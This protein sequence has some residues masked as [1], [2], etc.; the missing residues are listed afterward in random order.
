MS[1]RK[2]FT[3]GVAALGLGLFGGT[4]VLNHA[5]YN[6]SYIV[7]R[8]DDT[9]Q[10]VSVDVQMSFPNDNVM[11]VTSMAPTEGKVT[12]SDL[13]QSN[14][15]SQGAARG[16]DT[17]EIQSISNIDNHIWTS[18]QASLAWLKA[19]FPTKTEAE[20]EPYLSVTES[21][22]TRREYL[23]KGY[24]FDVLGFRD[25]AP[26]S[27]TVEGDGDDIPYFVD[28]TV[29]AHAVD[30]R[31]KITY[32]MADGT[33]LPD[34]VTSNNDGGTGD[35]KTITGYSGETYSDAQYHYL[36]PEVAGYTASTGQVTFDNSKL[37]ADGNQDVTITYTKTPTTGTTGGGSATTTTS[38]ASDTSSMASTASTIA[39][40]QVYGKRAL[41][42]YQNVD[43]K[44]SE[45]VQRY[46]KKAKT[47]AP[48]FTVVEV[49]KSA[50]GHT[51]YE[52]NDG[53]YITANS[54]YVGNLYW[55][56]AGYTNLYVTNPK[57]INTHQATTFSDK[58]RHLKQ[59]AAVGVTKVVKKG[60]MTRY[61]LADGTYITG[62]KEFV[63]PTRPL[64]VIRVKTKATVRLYKTVNLKH[65]IKTYKRGTT[66]TI[67]GWD[68]SH[69][70][71]SNQAGTKRYR[72]AGGY[73]TANNHF[74]KTIQ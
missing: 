48:V 60:Q 10:N 3:L 66:I 45:R 9:S 73:I 23:L 50:A 51:R 8:A 26:L 27:A 65:V 28:Y 15:D 46:A 57:G 32:K 71:D 69:G 44:K 17:V 62:N 64:K 18:E 36:I 14:E 63:S 7:A 6:G 55:K 21:I 5:N 2:S 56:G 40:Y 39:P 67:K 34:V 58:G 54:D 37:D 29:P 12:Y 68:Y 42:R 11:H 35:T 19:Q 31:M 53:T 25:T 4:I 72:V 13:V 61:Q 41:Y 33:A 43:F 49:A 22:L 1:V 59:G 30:T 20:L 38:S 52:L 70:R 24:A 74:V 47:Y 16:S